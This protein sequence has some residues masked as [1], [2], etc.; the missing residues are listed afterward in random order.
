MEDLRVSLRLHAISREEINASINSR[1]HIDRL[2]ET[3]T[4]PCIRLRTVNDTPM[5]NRS[6]KGL[7]RA[8]YQLEVYSEDTI[9]ATQ[10]A[11]TLL[12]VYDG[13][14]GAI[15]SFDTRILAQDIPGDWGPAERLFMRMVEMDVG[16]VST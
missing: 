14:Q 8:V 11:L 7:G 6:A 3:V 5:T 4:M 10:I 2:P 1:F 15:G 13:Y 12:D 16:Y 9:E